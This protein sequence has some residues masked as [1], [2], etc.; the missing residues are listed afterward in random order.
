MR[1]P[2]QMDLFDLEPTTY[3]PKA[4][5]INP[6]AIGTMYVC[7][8]CGE[9]VAYHVDGD[10]WVDDLLKEECRNGHRLDWEGIR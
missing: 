3:R 8:K 6:N 1:E 4:Q 5:K 2:Y 9:M 10:G 7:P